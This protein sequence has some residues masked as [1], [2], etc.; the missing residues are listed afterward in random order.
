MYICY[1]AGASPQRAR[2]LRGRRAPPG[3]APRGALGAPSL[4]FVVWISGCR[5]P[6]N[7][8]HMITI[9][10]IGTI[11]LLLFL[12]LLLL[13]LLYLLFLSVPGQ[14]VTLFAVDFRAP[15]CWISEVHHQYL[16]NQL[17]TD[18]CVTFNE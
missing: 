2:G 15:D 4:G 16:E 17:L 13:R 5:D 18:R 6:D 8:D 14:L 11:S 7:Y 1:E 9:V 10:I 3:R 12:S